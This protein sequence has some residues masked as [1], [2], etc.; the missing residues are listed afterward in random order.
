MMVSPRTQ[1]AA[2]SLTELM[3]VVA[4]MAI[5]YVMF[6]SFGSET[7]QKSQIAKCSDNL[8]K[9]FLSMQI[10]ANDFGTFPLNTNAQTSEE[11][12]GVLVP[13]YTSDTSIFVCPGGRDS[14]IPSGAPLDKH[15]ISYAFYMGCPTNGNFLMSDRQINTL[16]KDPGDQVFSL[17][18]KSP[19]NNHH[20]YGGN[21]LFCD[22]SVQASPPLASFSLAFSNNIVLLNPKR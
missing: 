19:G 9:I 5:L 13:R 4:L 16:S 6:L 2:F 18:G 1:A 20:K 17:N 15:K 22:G 3:L 11:A 7:H 8:Q 10:Y 21:V 12:L 14:Q